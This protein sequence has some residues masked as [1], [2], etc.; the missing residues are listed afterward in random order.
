VS[1]EDIPADAGEEDAYEFVLLHEG[2]DC[3]A[4]THNGNVTRYFTEDHPQ[5]FRDANHH[6]VH[7]APRKEGVNLPL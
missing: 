3:F 1:G 7:F 2:D 6:E 4:D 5:R